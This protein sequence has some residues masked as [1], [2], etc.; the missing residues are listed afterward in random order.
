MQGASDKLWK[1][2][3]LM[4][5]ANG[6]DGFTLMPFSQTGITFSNR[7]ELRRGLL[8]QNRMNGSGLAAGDIDGDGLCDLYFCGL[9]SD[10]RLYRNRGH[11]KFEDVTTS[12]G[13]TSG[14]QDFTGAV[15]A[16]TDGD[17][18]LDLLVTS[19]GGG[20]RL[21]QNQG[22]GTFRETTDAAG[23]RRPAGSTSMALADVD[24]DGD[25]DLYVTNIPRRPVRNDPS[26]RYEIQEVNGIRQVVSIS[27]T[28][29][30]D[31]ELAGRFQVTE[32]GEVLE[33]GEADF[34]YINN[35]DG[36]FTLSSF[37]DGRFLDESGV[38]LKSPPMDWGLSPHFHDL[39]GDG[40]PDLY[41]CN[42]LF[43]PDRIWMNQGK[44]I[45]RMLPAL[46]IRHT[47]LASM[48]MDVADINHDGHYDLFVTDMLS[49]D[50][51]LKLTQF[52]HVPPRMW[53]D[54][55]IG[56]RL[57]FNHNTLLLNRGDSTYSEIA[58]FSGVA[59]SDWSWGGVF[60]DVD[61]DGFE[62]LLIATGQQRNLAHADFA[63]R[64]KEL[65]RQQGTV[66]I[67]DMLKVSADFPPLHVPK[68]AFRNRGDLTFEE[69]GSLW[70]F[71]TRSASQ[72]M[73]LADLD[74]DGD[75]DVIINSLDRPA[76]VYRNDGIKPRIAVR[77]RGI[78][79]N[80][81]GIGAEIQVRSGGFV[82]HQ[83][84]ISGGRYLS[85]DQSMRV[86]ATR[87]ASK[88]DLDIR[89]RSGRRT[90]LPGASPNHLYE[91]QEPEGVVSP[92]TPSQTAAKSFFEDV[93]DRLQH[94]HSETSF[95]DLQFQPL[96]PYR[97]TRTGP[98]VTW[99]D[100]NGDGLD[101]LLI[102]GGQGGALAVYLN[103]GSGGF[104]RVTLRSATQTLS[105]DQTMV[106]G[107]NPGTTNA[108]LV[109]GSSNY[110]PSN[111]PS[112]AIGFFSLGTAAWMGKVE[113]LDGPVGA[114]AMADIDGDGDLDLFVGTTAKPSHHPEP[115][116][117]YLFRNDAGSFVMAEH[118]EHLGLV[119]GA[120]FSDL[121]GDGFPELLLA[122]EWGPIRILANTKGK[123]TD[124]TA[125]FGLASE[126]GFWQGITTG[127]FDG[128]GR[129]DIVASNW[130]LNSS[131][132]STQTHPLRFYYGDDTGEGIV[133]IV[134]AAVE[135]GTRAEYSRVN[136]NLLS[137]AMPF[138][139]NRV[140]DYEGY[141]TIT[142]PDLLGE[143]LAKMTQ[144]DIRRLESMVFLNRGNRFEAHPLPAE[145]QFAPA[146]GVVVADFDGDGTEDVGLSQNSFTLGAGIHRQDAGRSLWLKGN[147]KGG[148]QAVPAQESGWIVYGEQ[149]GCAASDFD[150]DGRVDIVLTQNNQATK[151]LLNRGA[152]PGIRVR[153]KGPK[154]N[155]LGIGAIVRVGK[156]G[157]WGPAREVHGGSGYRS[158]DTATPVLS[159]KD[160][161]D[162]IQ[163]RWPGGTVTETGI[164]A[165]A[166]QVVV[167]YSQP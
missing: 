162:R 58:F 104:R 53:E 36:T 31:P 57:Q 144:V 134:E 125:S 70:H 25:L 60:L 62:D 3:P 154:A 124:A 35:G 26:A 167:E 55:V 46:A 72:G 136:L 79:L 148:F 95:N 86:F 96:L 82:Q 102:P 38:P 92:S 97:L 121:N 99:F 155:P 12:S 157:H 78:G 126:T 43:T 61:L 77:L 131:L 117:G 94:V 93:S 120:V 163:V 105:A 84:M 156:E 44:G 161:P 151:L 85:G 115:G 119:K 69:A 20:V 165:T 45:F 129:M 127:D 98:G 56:E 91:I 33:F 147:G 4:I 111:P 47:S 100:L 158:M 146:Y 19:L 81:S 15:F 130:G 83:E 8:N 49:R 29:I 28:P 140:S 113:T 10:N 54:G 159:R 107:W 75:M 141:A 153:L 30:T 135:S 122:C 139:R 21:F 116:G 110:K 41:V 106:L 2:T 27:G 142:L 143:S 40:L 108:L 166:N 68:M 52:A 160:H 89:W 7:L 152:E 64:M 73:A 59:D 128:D 87:D 90:S 137:Q 42:D 65:Q 24:G 14:G 103:K 164:S 22:H 112:P 18:D 67:D 39:N 132:Q 37:T 118:W 48:G 74:N 51:R 13:I 16:D 80:T 5:P 88:V 150:G 23:L 109:V 6:Q 114:L 71:D 123:L 101:D 133:N 50:R 63:T 11:W 76:E 9:Q 1:E 145:A 66:S 149:R 17:G 32:T 34:L 138:I